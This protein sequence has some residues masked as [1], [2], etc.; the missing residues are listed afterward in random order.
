MAFNINN[1]G[2]DKRD[3]EENFSSVAP[4]ETDALKLGE[5]LNWAGK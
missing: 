4:V 5:T 2:E 3:E 1:S